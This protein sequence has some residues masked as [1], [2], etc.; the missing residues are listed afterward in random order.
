MHPFTGRYAAPLLWPRL[1]PLRP[2]DAVADILLRN[3]RRDEEVSQGKTLLLRS[4]AAGFTCARVRVI[5]GRPRPLPGYPTAPALYP[6]SVRRLRALASGF[7]P[8]PPRGDAVAF[9]LRFPS[10]GLAEDCHLLH[11]R[12]AWHTINSPSPEGGGS[13]HSAPD[14]A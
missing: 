3:A 9:G 12:H 14:R 5:I 8:P 7:L 6:V 1:T 10:P 4:G 11:Q 13:D 2:P